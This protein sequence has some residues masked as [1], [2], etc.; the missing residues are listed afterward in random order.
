[1]RIVSNQ[2]RDLTGIKELPE[3][4]GYSTMLGV[5]ADGFAGP[6][7]VAVELAQRVLEQADQ[8]LRGAAE[9]QVLRFRMVAHRQR[10]VPV[11]ARLQ[12]AALVGARPWT[13]CSRR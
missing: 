10:L 2:I 6:V 1:M 9:G 5:L 13:R 7:L 4:A 3:A 12:H 8:L 11:Q